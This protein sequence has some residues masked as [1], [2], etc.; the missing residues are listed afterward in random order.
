[1]THF[2]CI[3]LYYFK[4]GKNATEMQKKKKICAVYGE[5][6]V[7]DQMCQKW[8]A[9]FFAGDFSLG[10]APQSGRPN[11]VDSNQI[12]TLIENNQLSYHMGDNQHTQNVQINKVIGEN[13]KC[14]IY[15]M[16]KAIQTF[17]PTPKFY[18]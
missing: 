13:E 14:V 7:T 4:K 8:F 18:I 5:G 11:E 10:N 9:K 2:W 6:T 15:F 3:M 1:M 17:W 12:E 16:E